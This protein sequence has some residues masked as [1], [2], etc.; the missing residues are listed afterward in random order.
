MWDGSAAAH[1]A[2]SPQKGGENIQAT[3]G[4]P[5]AAEAQ[6]HTDDGTVEFQH[7]QQQ[8]QQEH[9]LQPSWQQEFNADHPDARMLQLLS[10][11]EARD[12]MQGEGVMLAEALSYAGDRVRVRSALRFPDARLQVG[13]FD[14]FGSL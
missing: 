8:Q 1:A 2:S 4:G 14:N 5:R 3:G 13:D 11:H 9:G 10:E 7:Q 6:A 12:A